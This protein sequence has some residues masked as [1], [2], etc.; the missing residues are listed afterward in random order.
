[1]DIGKFLQLQ[2]SLH[3]DDE[4]VSTPEIEEI[5]GI[6]IFL[7]NLFDGFILQKECRDRLWEPLDRVDDLTVFAVIESVLLPEIEC[8]EEETRD[9]SDECLGRCNSDLRPCSCEESLSGRSRDR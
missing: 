7:G 6:S 3:R 8:E 5:F 2:R 9:L 1:M 4:L